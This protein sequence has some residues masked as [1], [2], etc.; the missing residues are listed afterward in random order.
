[1]SAPDLLDVEAYIRRAEDHYLDNGDADF[2]IG[3]LH[4]FLRAAFEIMTPE[5]RV[6]FRDHKAVVLTMAGWEEEPY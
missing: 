4:A 1:M 2:E 3:D 6:A 5:Q